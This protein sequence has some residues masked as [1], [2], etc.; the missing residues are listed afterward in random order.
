MKKVNEIVIP[1]KIRS[2][3]SKS[4]KQDRF[5]RKKTNKAGDE[6]KAYKFVRCKPEI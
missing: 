5:P 4:V 1:Q 6:G 3:I 2:R